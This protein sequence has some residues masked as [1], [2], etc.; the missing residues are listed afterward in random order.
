MKQTR[1]QSLPRERPSSQRRPALERA[2]PSPDMIQDT[3]RVWEQRLGRP[4]SQ[5]DARQILRN[6]VG[7]F[8]VLQRWQQEGRDRAAETKKVDQPEF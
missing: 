7:F 4:L 3:I 2:F 5:E 6:V 1:S 8:R